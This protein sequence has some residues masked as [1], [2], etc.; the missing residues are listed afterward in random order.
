[1][2]QLFMGTTVLGYLSLCANKLLQGQELPDPSDSKVWQAAM[3][4]GGGLGLYGDF[5]FGEYSRYGRP[6]SSEMLG[7]VLSDIN[8]IAELY[9]KAK[10]GSWSKV[11][12]Q[13]FNL[14]KRN[15]PGRNLFYL[16]PI[17]AL[18]G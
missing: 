12:T 4:K 1:M 9:T 2:S 11:E 16:E 5:L 14:I 8:S 17:M 13:S 10:A 15:I 18:F 3:L 7:P 6:L